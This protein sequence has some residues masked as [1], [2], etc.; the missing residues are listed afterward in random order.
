MWSRAILR[1]PEILR[2]HRRAVA[3]PLRRLAIRSVRA[4]LRSGAVASSQVGAGVLRPAVHGAGAALGERSA[5][6]RSCLWR[7]V[8]AGLRRALR[9][10]HARW[11]PQIIRAR[12]ALGEPP[13][14]F[15]RPIHPPTSP[16]AIASLRSGISLRIAR[17]W[18]IAA[19]LTLRRILR[20]TLAGAISLRSAVGRRLG[21]RPLRL[22]T[23]RPMGPIPIPTLV[24]SAFAPARHAPG[25]AEFVRR[26]L[27][28]LV[29][30]H[31][32]QHVGG[33]REF[34]E[35]ER[36]V[37]VCIEPGEK[38]GCGFTPIAG[39]SVTLRA[40]FASGLRATLR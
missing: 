36:T 8:A 37:M 38:S 2:S 21:A 32:A 17:R 11:H 27:A 13:G 24:I 29:S 40:G 30:V 4:A 3:T 16:M 20:A 26:H 33:F 18:P 5:I 39:R 34:A 25:R 31:A 6:P 9:A 28:V 15:R 7:S 14:D 10:L 12:A 22:A 1:T 35:I 19:R 23:F